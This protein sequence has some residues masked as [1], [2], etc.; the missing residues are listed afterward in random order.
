MFNLSSFSK[1]KNDLTT[2]QKHI[3]KTR[4]Y[5]ILGFSFGIQNLKKTKNTTLSYRRINYEM[6]L[7]LDQSYKIDNK[8]R[9][10]KTDWKIIDYAWSN[11]WYLSARKSIGRLLI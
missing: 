11:R 2:Q 1:K 4:P 7:E 6:V 10:V 3:L 8:Q 5:K 9:I